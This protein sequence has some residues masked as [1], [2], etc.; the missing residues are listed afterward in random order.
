VAKIKSQSTLGGLLSRKR[1]RVADHIYGHGF[2]YA[3]LTVI[4]L[5]V[6]G[7]GGLF[8]ALDSDLDRRDKQ[9]QAI[10]DAETRQLTEAFNAGQ[11]R[12]VFEDGD[13]CGI[14]SFTDA[15]GQAFVAA[16]EA[17]RLLPDGQVAE[18]S[19]QPRLRVKISAPP[20]AHKGS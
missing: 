1:Q 8:Y 20:P 13:T 10:I 12:I 11:K 6:C 18:M 16:H 17:L 5:A 4:S 7:T 19:P 15:T 3:P 9:K 2:L 14:V